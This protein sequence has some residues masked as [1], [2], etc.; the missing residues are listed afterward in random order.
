MATLASI[1]RPLK[2]RFWEKV[3]TGHPDE[4]WPWAALT[5][6][7]GYG[8]LRAGGAAD[9]GKM[10]YAHRAAWLLVNGAIP[11]GMQVCHKCDNRKCVNP[12]HLFLGTI[13]ENMADK[14]S[15]NRH[16]FGEK[17]P[18]ARLT[19]RDVREIRVSADT[20]ADCAN[21]FGVSFQHISDIRHGK[22]WAHV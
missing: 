19:E 20:L 22:R 18:Q 3:S 9:G 15:K 10:I 7:H 6:Q 21:K 11:D 5:R 13:Q 2:D 8:V 12:G 4:C 14:V 17:S 16:L 1:A